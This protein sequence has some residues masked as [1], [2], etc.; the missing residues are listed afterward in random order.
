MFDGTILE[1]AK[2][3]HF[4]G[5]GGSGMFPIVQI[6]HGMGYHISGSDN[7]PGSI[8]DAERAIGIPVI[9]G[10]KAENIK[11]AELIVYTAAILPDNPELAA[12][13]AS[14]V[15]LIERAELLGWLTTQYKDPICVCGT[16]GKTTTTS[17]LTQ[18]LLGAGFDPSA[19]IGGK[20]PA[21]GG[22][23]RRGQSGTFVCE[24]CEF[25]DHFLKL[26]PSI[27]V[28]LNIDN[29]HMEYF[30]TIDN[31]VR[32]FHTFA[33]MARDA[34]LYNADDA[35][36]RKAVEGITGKDLVSFGWGEGCEYR[37][38]N[39]RMPG[40]A[41]SVFTLLHDGVPVEDFTL[42]VPGRHN[43]LNAVAAI[44]AAM[45][46][47]APVKAVQEHLAAFR[48]AGR[49][50]EILGERGG[51]TIADDYAH[52]PA[53]LAATLTAAKELPF[54]KVW[55]VFQ[56]FTYSRTK[57]L[58]DDFAKALQIADYVVM[59]EIMGSREKNT[60]GVYTS[61]LAEKV[62]GSV[63]FPAFPEIAAYVMEHAKE[64]DL[65]LT[66]GCGDV[67]KCAHMMLEAQNTAA[68]G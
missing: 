25:Q 27:A 35:N 8:V 54:R 51:V 65:V 53:E 1:T 44:A 6:L 31:A 63:W 67:Y 14:G 12:A 57:L 20:L 9:L 49:R 38:A 43:V 39:L 58:M 23:G 64:G 21:I 15:P 26:S 42:H 10:Q 47:G 2:Q 4:I 55:A 41:E 3:I 32:S 5:I 62:P 50:F 40:G 28:I 48:G 13:R 7:N 16:H 34:V 61:Q 59:S 68:A 11:G 22:Y 24:A 37:P 18:I 30:G 56:P 19:V 60:E 29:D 17:M 33:G 46:R 45:Y 66:L 36:T 52:H